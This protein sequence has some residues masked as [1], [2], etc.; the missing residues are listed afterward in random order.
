MVKGA[1]NVSRDYRSKNQRHGGT[2]RG[3]SSRVYVYS[4]R[5]ELFFLVPSQFL[6]P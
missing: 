1:E 6:R 3:E 5:A 4:L 2:Y